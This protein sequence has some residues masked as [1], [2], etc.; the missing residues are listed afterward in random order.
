MAG[1]VKYAKMTVSKAVIFF[2]E[3]YY[4]KNSNMVLMAMEV[5]IYKATM[6]E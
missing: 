2:T 6:S 4:L 3:I 5:Q 1:D